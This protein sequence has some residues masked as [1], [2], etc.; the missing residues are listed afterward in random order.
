MPES[1]GFG[2]DFPALEAPFGSM[3]WPDDASDTP[4]DTACSPGLHRV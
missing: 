4:E 3:I 2:V 1:E